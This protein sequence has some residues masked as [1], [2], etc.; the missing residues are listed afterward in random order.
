MAFRRPIKEQN[1]VQ[2][3]G[4]RGAQ[5]ILFGGRLPWNVAVEHVDNA[6]L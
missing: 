4:E 2:R 1:K 6:A 3:D 5:E